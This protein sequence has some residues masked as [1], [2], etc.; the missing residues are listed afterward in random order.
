[1]RWVDNTTPRPLYPPGKTRYPL[2]RRL[3]GPQDR[4]GQGRKISAPTGI[5]SPDRPARSDSLY[6]IFSISIWNVYMAW[7]L[8]SWRYSVTCKSFFP[9]KSVLSENR[10]AY[11]GKN[12]VKVSF[13]L[14]ICEVFSSLNIFHNRVLKKYLHLCGEPINVHW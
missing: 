7:K 5:R 10:Y 14:H 3:G 1:M 8:L 12:N 4:S 11:K 9:L 13:R 2:Y 6:R